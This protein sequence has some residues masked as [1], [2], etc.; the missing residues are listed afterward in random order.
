VLSRELLQRASANYTEM[1]QIAKHCFT[2]AASVSSTEEIE[3]G[4]YSEEWLLNY[5]LGKIAEKLRRPP[6]EYLDHYQKVIQLQC[7]SAVSN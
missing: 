5:M 1:L 7:D 2:M 6:A 3:P 4:G